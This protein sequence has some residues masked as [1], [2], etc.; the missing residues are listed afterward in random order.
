M[1]QKDTVQMPIINKL[2]S[3]DLDGEDKKI[4]NEII[5]QQVNKSSSDKRQNYA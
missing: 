1:V 5:E 3:V 4:I 2:E